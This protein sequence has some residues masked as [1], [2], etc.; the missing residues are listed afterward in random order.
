M[1]DDKKWERTSS[2]FLNC[3]YAI[4]AVA[5]QNVVGLLAHECN[6]FSAIRNVDR[7][8]S[9]VCF[10]ITGAIPIE[11]LSAIAPCKAFVF[12]DDCDRVFAL[13]DFTCF[14]TTA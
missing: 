4:F 9:N 6:K 3:S 11:I 7:L 13:A 2:K 10:S 1:S 5:S 12:A 8:N 14:K